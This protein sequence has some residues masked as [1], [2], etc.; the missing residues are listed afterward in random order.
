MRR[1]RTNILFGGLAGFISVALLQLL[2]IDNEKISPIFN[3]ATIIF[4]FTL[5]L[6]IFFV[7][8][9]NEFLN[10]KKTDVPRWYAAL[11][12]FT[13]IFGFLGITI[14][15]LHFGIVQFIF[16]LLVSIAALILFN[17][18][19]ENKNNFSKSIPKIAK[20]KTTKKGRKER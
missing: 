2:A 8:S 7:L 15:F 18:V 9:A 13:I 20:K 3:W 17:I 12:L 10:I 16:F 6:S 5:P 4:S 19:E 14:L 11:A 1:E